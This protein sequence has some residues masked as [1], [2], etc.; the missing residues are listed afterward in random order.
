MT[1]TGLS[2]D[3]SV[4]TCG[5]CG[6]RVTPAAVTCPSCDALLAAYEAPAGSA[7]ASDQAT[8]TTFDPAPMSETVAPAEPVIAPPQRPEPAPFDAEAAMAEARRTLGMPITPEPAR[9]PEAVAK[10][11]TVH[12]SNPRLSPSRFRNRNP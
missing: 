4:R 12:K 1:E 10:A 7:T 8:R 2:Q 11:E 6:A 3:K 5:N 9:E